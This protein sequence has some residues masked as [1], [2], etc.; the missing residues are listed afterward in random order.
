MKGHVRSVFLKPSIVTIAFCQMSFM[1]LADDTVPFLRHVL[2]QM[3]SGT[4]ASD[5]SQLYDSVSGQLCCQRI[6]GLVSMLSDMF[7]G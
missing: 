5:R 6:H 3:C 1:C 7:V 2:S 4:R